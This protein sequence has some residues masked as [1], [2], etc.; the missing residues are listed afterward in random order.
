MGAAVARVMLLLQ[1]FYPSFFTVFLPT[2]LLVT[3]VSN[4]RNEPSSGSFFYCYYFV[5]SIN[6]SPS[7]G[8]KCGSEKFVSCSF[9][10]RGSSQLG[11]TPIAM[12]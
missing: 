9:T 2:R 1:S 4:K 5:P 11:F 6:K 8:L 7:V 3:E 12:N 10:D